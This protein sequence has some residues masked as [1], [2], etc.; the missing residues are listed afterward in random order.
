MVAMPRN[1]KRERII[2]G[3]TVMASEDSTRA[4]TVPQTSD[5]VT[6]IMTVLDALDKAPG[7]RHQL[8]REF[9]SEAVQVTREVASQEVEQFDFDRFVNM[10][11]PVAERFQER[12]ALL[13]YFFSKLPDLLTSYEDEDAEQLLFV[14]EQQHNE[15]ERIRQKQNFETEEILKK[16]AERRQK[17]SEIREKLHTSQAAQSTEVPSYYQDQPPSSPESPA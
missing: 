14:L 5:K 4:L 15:W 9:R 2:E 8:F 17:I 3:E 7:I 10:W 11:K 16:I 6:E 13:E 1:R 12:R